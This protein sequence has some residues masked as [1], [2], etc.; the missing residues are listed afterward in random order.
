M[1]II[2]ASLLRQLFE[3]RTEASAVIESFYDDHAKKIHPME[4]E[5]IE[6]LSA[7]IAEC[8]ETYIVIDAL[9]E[10]IANSDKAIENLLRTFLSLGDRVKLMITSRFLGGINAICEK[11]GGKQWEL[12]GRE[13][14]IR[15]YVE[16]RI[17]RDISFA[18]CHSELIVEKVLQ[19]SIGRY[20]LLVRLKNDLLDAM[21]IFACSITY[22]LA[23]TVPLHRRNPGSA[24]KTFTRHQ[25]C[26]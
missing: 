2:L 13:D 24:Q 6:T 1:S 9:D 10:Y 8:R 15:R 16:A 19:A 26:V 7:S 21:Q 5:I 18:Q 23:I 3:A 14:D 12:H 4:K 22:G 17:D 20:V 25:Y 11:L